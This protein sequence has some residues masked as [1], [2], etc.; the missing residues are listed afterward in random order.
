MVI[1]VDKSEEF[2]KSGKKL[3]SEYEGAKWKEELWD[4]AESNKRMDVI[5]QNGNTLKV[6]DKI[7]SCTRM[8]VRLPWDFFH[9]I[10]MYGSEYQYPI[11]GKESNMNGKC[12]QRTISIHKL[13]ANA[14]MSVDDFPPER[15]ADVYHT[16][17]ES[18][19]QWIRETVIINHINHDPTDNRVENLEYVTPREN[20]H[21]AIKQYGGHFCPDQY[22][23]H[24]TK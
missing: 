19:K 22:L 7:I 17:P 24:Q 10:N 11:Q 21:K 8:T 1:K 3:I 14:H 9:D 16:L 13:V 23:K 2:K 20:C 4:E 6:G 18:V 15:I 12:V 5:G